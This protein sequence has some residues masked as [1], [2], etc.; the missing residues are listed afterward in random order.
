MSDAA[1]PNINVLPFALSGASPSLHAQHKEQSFLFIFELFKCLHQRHSHNEARRVAD[2]SVGISLREG[3]WENGG[4][5]A[6]LAGK[7]RGEDHTIPIRGV[8]LNLLTQPP[9]PQ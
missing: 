2:H 5:V 9:I 8:Y 4:V 7:Y 3:E 1:A 6:G